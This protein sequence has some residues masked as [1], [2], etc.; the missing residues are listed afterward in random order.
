MQ[1]RGKTLSILF[2]SGLTIFAQVDMAMGVG[3][4]T[5]MVNLETYYL[6]QR[7]CF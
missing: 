1:N 2:G 3:F 4:P 5:S 6:L 7:I